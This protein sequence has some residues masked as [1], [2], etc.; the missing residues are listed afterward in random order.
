MVDIQFEEIFAEPQSLDSLRTVS[1]LA[2]ME[3]LRRG[4]RLSVQPV[5]KREFETIVK[6]GHGAGRR[7]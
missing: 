6:L 1:A 7:K 4:S 2:K 5:S 3:L